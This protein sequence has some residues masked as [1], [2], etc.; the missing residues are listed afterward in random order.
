MR[1]VAL[2]PLPYSSTLPAP[3]SAAACA[4]PG[5]GFL[6]YATAC[7]FIWE[8]CVRVYLCAGLLVC[9]GPWM[10]M[11]AGRGQP[12]RNSRDT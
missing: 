11:C 7:A 9:V 6:F 5:Q 3:H 4:W 12:V 1:K 8:L 2:D 10:Q